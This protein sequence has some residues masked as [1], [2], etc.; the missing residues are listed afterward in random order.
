MSD[1]N[2]QRLD[3]WLDIACLSPTRSQARRAIEAG[4]VHVGGE[5][6]K[7]ARLVG[8]GDEIELRLPGRVRTFVV[9]GLC[10]HNV[11]RALARTLYEET[12]PTPEQI[13]LRRAMRA[14]KVLRPAG[15]GRPT[16]RDRRRLDRLR[17]D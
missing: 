12:P 17:G 13:D 10:E 8:I 1:E 14:V 4:H 5:R 16:K 2:R 3:V 11:A 15:A 6:A 9:R 7:P